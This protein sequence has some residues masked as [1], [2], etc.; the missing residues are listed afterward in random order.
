MQKYFLLFCFIFYI[1]LIILSAQPVSWTIPAV[2]TL[3]LQTEQ[4]DYDE[5]YQRQVLQVP[6]QV[7]VIRSDIEFRDGKKDINNQLSLWVSAYVYKINKTNSGDFFYLGNPDPD[8]IEKKFKSGI[9]WVEKK[10]ILDSPEALRTKD[11]IYRRLIVIDNRQDSRV[12]IYQAPDETSEKVSDTPRFSFFY[13]YKEDPEPDPQTKIEYFLIGAAPKVDIENAGRDILGWVSQKN[14]KEWNTRLAADYLE[15]TKEQRQQEEEQGQSGLIRVYDSI[16]NAVVRP[17]TS[18]ISQENPKVLR[19]H[20]TPRDP[21]LIAESKEGKRLFQIASLNGENS[22]Q[23]QIILNKIHTEKSKLRLLDILILVD[24]S[25]PREA[26]MKITNTLPQVAKKIMNVPKNNK[27]FTLDVAWSG[28]FFYDFRPGIKYT[29]HRGEVF[30]PIVIDLQQQFQINTTS[31]VNYLYNF[32]YR[33]SNYEPRALYYAIDTAASNVN[34]R[35]GSSRCI[36]V[37]GRTG[38]HDITSPRHIA[39]DLNPATIKEGLQKRGVYLYGIQF[40]EPRNTKNTNELQIYAKQM[41][42]ICANM[43]EGGYLLLSPVQGQDTIRQTFDFSIF[44]EMIIQH[45]RQQNELTE[46]L[47]TDLARGFLP[48]EILQRYQVPWKMLKDSIAKDIEKKAFPPTTY[49][50]IRS[51]IYVPDV[52]VVLQQFTDRQE[53]DIQELKKN[54]SFYIPGW[55]WEFNPIT[56]T[57]QIE[58]CMLIDKNEM[59]RLLTFLATLSQKLK[60]ADTPAQYIQ[61]WKTLLQSMF[62]IDTIPPN[63]PLDNLISQ[64]SGL[65]FMNGILKYTLDEFISLAQNPKFRSEIINKLDITCGDLHAILYEQEVEIVRRTGSTEVRQNKRRWWTEPSSGEIYAWVEVTKFP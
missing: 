10:Y 48:D 26:R 28:G 33:P 30:K 9:G 45:R 36:I 24:A 62:G 8:S 37:V 47:V 38:N 23:A 51:S 5:N 63:E 44:L 60:N 57:Q 54:S 46:R 40:N 50:N 20:D 39:N 42:E 7:V 4:I 53:I 17:I 32:N 58:V 56:N 3:P 41:T 19:S 35:D 22:S 27:T 59:A 12:P 14:C 29:Y 13:I 11:K 64:H 25:L 2:G 16:E 18:V 55:V 52:A 31:V 65:P 34:W 1:N 6:L 43:N 61:I 15:K 21:L 49:G